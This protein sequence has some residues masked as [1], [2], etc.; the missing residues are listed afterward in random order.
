M[1]KEKFQAYETVR[2]SG[3]TNML[4][5]R[6]VIELAEDLTDTEL[7]RDEVLDII[8]NYTAYKETYS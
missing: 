7:T 1:I 2:E 3:L 8:E 6:N 4:D 5:V